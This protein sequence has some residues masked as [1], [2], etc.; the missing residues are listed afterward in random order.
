MP[1]LKL[2]ANKSGLGSSHLLKS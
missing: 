1:K 2:C